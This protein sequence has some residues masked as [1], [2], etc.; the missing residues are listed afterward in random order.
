MKEVVL[1]GVGG[2]LGANA[3]Y[4]VGGWVAARMGSTF[5][6][7]TLVINV[8]GSFA[9]GL[10]MGAAEFGTIAPASRLA[11]AV[12]FL[13]AY[14]TFSTFTYETL[15]LIESGSLLLAAAN[16]VASTLVGL[17]GVFVGALIGRVLAG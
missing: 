11:F 17:A 16:V 6:Y 8:S 4:W 2:F 12:G 5:P 3:R 15:R 13:G 7:G 1:I 14:T 10:L 9:L